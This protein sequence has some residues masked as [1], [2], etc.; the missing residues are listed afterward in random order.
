MIPSAGTQGR[1]SV[2]CISWVV[3]SKPASITTQ[4]ARSTIPKPSAVHRTASSLRMNIRTA[5]PATGTKTMRLSSGI[6]IAPYLQTTA[7]TRMAA[8]RPAIIAST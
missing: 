8:I 3:V 7:K 2:N 4:R 6:D 1:L 5:A